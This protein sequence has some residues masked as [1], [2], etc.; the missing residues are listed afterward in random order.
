[1]STDTPSKF[2]DWFNDWAGVG[3]PDHPLTR[4]LYQQRQRYKDIAHAAWKAS[5]SALSANRASVP[6]AWISK[7]GLDWLK[8][9]SPKCHA[10][11]SSVTNDNEIEDAF[12]RQGRN[13]PGP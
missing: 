8:L 9:A 12:F 1:M 2:D 13:Q 10:E 3:E 11:V 4:E 5:T 6:V 7:E